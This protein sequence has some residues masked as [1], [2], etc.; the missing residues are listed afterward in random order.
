[1]E[2]QLIKLWNIL[3]GK[4]PITHNVGQQPPFGTTGLDP[5]SLVIWTLVAVATSSNFP[6]LRGYLLWPLLSFPLNPSLFSYI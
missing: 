5:Q 2:E 6:G 4:Y 1:M 3:F